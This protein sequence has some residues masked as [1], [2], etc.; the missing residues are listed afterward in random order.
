MWMAVRAG[1]APFAAY[2]HGG[3]GEA[4]S[5]CKACGQ[6]RED[7]HHVCCSCIHYRE[8]RAGLEAEIGMPATKENLMDILAL[9]TKVVPNVTAEQ[10]SRAVF[11]FLRKIRDKREMIEGGFVS[12]SVAQSL[13]C[14]NQ[15]ARSLPEEEGSPL[16]PP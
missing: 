3:G 13:G 5:G 6:G 14:G 10:L 2:K 8:E 9:D 7:I 12:V 11:K 15:G 4:K 1:G 16:Q